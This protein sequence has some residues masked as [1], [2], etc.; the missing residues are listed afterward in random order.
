MKISEKKVVS[1]D[2]RLNQFDL[3]Y[4]DDED[5][6]KCKVEVND[7]QDILN[8]ITSLLDLAYSEFS[9]ERKEFINGKSELIYDCFI[10]IDFHDG[11]DEI[12]VFEGG[13][14]DHYDEAS[15]K[16]KYILSHVLLSNDF[17]SNIELFDMLKKG[18]NK[19]LIPTPLLF[20]TKKSK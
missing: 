16:K 2:V 7:N 5:V 19:E 15:D 18:L 17:D 14:S 8:T 20:L 11:S 3:E 6:F 10:N 1:V 9:N 13:S 12:I 4:G